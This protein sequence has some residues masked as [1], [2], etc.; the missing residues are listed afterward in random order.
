MKLTDI[1][2]S[3]TLSPC[4][5]RILVSLLNIV[6]TLHMCSCN[7]GQNLN[8]ANARE[9]IRTRAEHALNFMNLVWWNY[10]LLLHSLLF[11]ELVS[12]QLLST[13]LSTQ[14]F[15][16]DDIFTMIFTLFWC[17]IAACW[18]ILTIFPSHPSLSFGALLLHDFTIDVL[19]FLL[20]ASL[21]FGTSF[22]LT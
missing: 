14:L 2:A 3:N 1:A 9:F 4:P 19:V 11:V 21:K 10:Y 16:M 18:S 15:L 17:N 20:V 5:S 22:M 7:L 6:K 13:K 8:F 12:R